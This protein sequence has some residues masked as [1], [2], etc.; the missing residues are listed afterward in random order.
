MNVLRG[1]SCWL[2]LFCLVGLGAALPG[3][4]KKSSAGT[5]KSVDRSQDNKTNDNTGKSK[6][7]GADINDG[8]SRTIATSSANGGTLPVKAKIP[9]KAKSNETDP[10]TVDKTESGSGTK[11]KLRGPKLDSDR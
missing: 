10:P 7:S 8:S 11:R 6:S 1:V 3:C 5:A 4:S 9:T 2:A